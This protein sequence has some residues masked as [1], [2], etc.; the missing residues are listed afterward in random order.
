NDDGCITS[1]SVL[2]VVDPYKPIFI[3]N[4]ITTNNDGINDNLTVYANNAATGIEVF[5]IFDRWGGLL[6]EGSGDEIINN[7]ANG[8]DGTVDGKPVSPGVYAYRAVVEFLDEIPVAYTGTV[9][10]LK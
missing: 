6:W 8:W 9:T 2:I 10:V 3:P 5:Q 7:P 4:V 1:D